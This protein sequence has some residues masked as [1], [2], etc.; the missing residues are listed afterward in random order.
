M[1]K[2]VKPVTRVEQLLAVL[3]DG[4]AY[5]AST[6]AKRVGWRFGAAIFEL[7]QLGCVIESWKD[8]RAGEWKYQ[9][10]Y[11]PYNFG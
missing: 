5:R 10:L 6:L 1:A 3:K 4:R 8:D 9:L 7:R 2:T 11:A